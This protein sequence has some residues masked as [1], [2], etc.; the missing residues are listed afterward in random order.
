M[1]DRVILIGFMCSGKSTV[2]RLLAERLGWDFLDFDATIEMEQGMDVHE[3]FARRGEAVFRALERDLTERI[4]PQRRVVLAPG[5]GWVTQP[6]LLEELRPGSLT[7]WL[8]V[9]PRTVLER[10]RRQGGVRPLLRVGPLE[11]QVPALITAR[12]PFY[13][14]ADYA[15]DTESRQPAELAAELADWVAREGDS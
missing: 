3:I 1:I 11:E 14:R 10:H 9:G 6:E 4:A 13:C 2:G 15:L 12:E 5:G 7:A 8:K